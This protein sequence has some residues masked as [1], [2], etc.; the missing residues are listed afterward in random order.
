MY[1]FGVN[2][3]TGGPPDPSYFLNTRCRSKN[4]YLQSALGCR[5]HKQQTKSVGALEDASAARLLSECWRQ[6]SRD[7]LLIELGESVGS[8]GEVME[9]AGDGNLIY[10]RVLRAVQHNGSQL[11]EVQQAESYF[12]TAVVFT[13]IIAEGIPHIFAIHRGRICEVLDRK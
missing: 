4:H 10:L 11:C 3:G 2:R 1:R 7:G 9:E 8:D 6:M 13:L 12:G 5:L